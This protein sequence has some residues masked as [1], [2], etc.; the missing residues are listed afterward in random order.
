MRKRQHSP[1]RRLRCLLLWLVFLLALAVGGKWAWQQPFAQAARVGWELQRMDAPDALPVPVDGVR[2]RD[3][4]DTWGGARSGG[5]KHEGVDIFAARG[6]PV[7]STTL[8][9]VM[10]VRDS[11]LGGKQVWVLGPGGERHYYAHLDA[12]KPGIERMDVLQVGDVLGYVGDTGNARGTPPHLHYGIYAS[13]G[14]Y[15]PWPLLQAQAAAGD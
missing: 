11:G 7:R 8:G 9:L 10:A 3:I 6:T 5:R 14:A 4:A 1:A 15:N 13:D 12:F 2:A